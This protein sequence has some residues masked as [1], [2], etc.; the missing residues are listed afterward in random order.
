MPNHI[1]VP[2]FTAKQLTDVKAKS[3]NEITGPNAKIEQYLTSLLEAGRLVMTND[4]LTCMDA[5]DEAIDFN[6]MKLRTLSHNP[7]DATGRRV[8]GKS[9]IIRAQ[10]RVGGG[11]PTPVMLPHSGIWVTILPPGEGKLL[12][13]WRVMTQDRVILGRYTYGAIF[14]ATSIVTT[15]RII[16]F[17]LG[18][19]EA[20]SINLSNTDETLG[21]FILETDLPFL[22]NGMGMSMHP[23][24]IDYSSPCIVDPVTCS[25]VDTGKLYPSTLARYSSSRIPESVKS[26]LASETPNSVTPESVRLYQESI[27]P[28]HREILIDESGLPIDMYYKVP[29]LNQ[30]I[31]IGEKWVSDVHDSVI[32]ALAM[33]P[34]ANVEEWSERNLHITR[35]GKASFLRQYAAWVS[36]IDMYDA[37]VVE[38]EDDIASVCMSLSSS[39]KLREDMTSTVEKYIRKSS[40]GLIGYPAHECPSCKRRPALAGNQMIALDPVRLFFKYLVLRVDRINQRSLL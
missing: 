23:R 27:A 13:L 14:S 37:G 29:T 32:T 30:A 5:D 36:K 25:H 24:G 40:I 21:D 3:L 33:E 16:E 19:V 10:S 2:N 4:V 22:F 11:I 12:D 20:H 6:G 34:P 28:E 9:A 1:D 8:S 26:T 15:R 18:Q 17:C 38:G 31:R 35:A 7:S 39:D